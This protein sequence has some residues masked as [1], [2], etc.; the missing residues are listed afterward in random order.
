MLVALGASAA[1]LYPFKERLVLFLVPSL[2]LLTGM[3]LA[4]IARALHAPLAST[5]AAS[6]ATL[7]VVGLSARALHWAPPVY[8]RE[9]I[10]PA[11]EHLRQN[12][13]PADALYVHYSAAPAFRFYE[14]RDSIHLAGYTIGRCHRSDPRS[15]LLELNAFRGGRV[16]VLFTHELPRLR[17]RETMTQY[18]SEIGTMRDSL[19]AL[20]QD[21]DGQPTRASLYLYDL[22]DTMRLRSA[23]SAATLAMVPPEV[24]PRL[25][26]MAD[27]SGGAVTRAR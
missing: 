14:A 6:G 25:R 16:W 21:V 8:R 12:R 23:P 17:E 3:G 9:E 19:V 11:L 7:L 26:C 2:L 5:L 1:L 10:T 4:A 18:L 13:K 20:G 15:Y 22:S 24:D 27:M